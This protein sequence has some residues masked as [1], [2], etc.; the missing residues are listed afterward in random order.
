MMFRQ[1]VLAECTVGIRE[2]SRS[3]KIDQVNDPDDF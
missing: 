1:M 3:F 2:E